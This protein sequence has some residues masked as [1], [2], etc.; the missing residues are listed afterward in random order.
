M[1]WC[2]NCRMFNVGAP[3]RCRYCSAGLEGRLCPSGHVNPPDK[4]LVYCGDCG[5]PLEP[6]WGS[7][8]SWRV[9]ILGVMVMALA[10]IVATAVADL[11][12]GGQ[13]LITVTMVGLILLIGFRLGFRLIPAWVRDMTAEVLSLLLRTVL[14]TGIKGKK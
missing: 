11:G 13:S 5:K 2:S 8:G 12:S 9:S 4:N 6:Q 14:G 3:Q 10:L 1:R 7:G